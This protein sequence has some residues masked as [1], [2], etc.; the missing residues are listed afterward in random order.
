[1]QNE[2]W[3]YW[4][5]FFFLYS[6]AFLNSTVKYRNLGGTSTVKFGTPVYCGY[7]EYRPSLLQTPL[8]LGCIQYMVTSVLQN[9]QNTF[10]ERSL[11]NAHGQESVADDKWPGH[12]VAS[13]TK[14][15]VRAVDPDTV[16]LA[17]VDRWITVDKQCLM[18]KQV[19]FFNL[20]SFLIIDNDG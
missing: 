9:Q 10:G 7:R 14:P 6:I 8:T 18:S 15:T 17:C 13:T 11:L 19:C 16:C 20:F 1:M 4:K 12:P 3:F 5:Q 2:K